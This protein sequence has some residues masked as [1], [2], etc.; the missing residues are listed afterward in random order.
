MFILLGTKEHFLHILSFYPKYL[1]CVFCEMFN[2]SLKHFQKN[3]QGVKER[4]TWGS[5]LILKQICIAAMDWIV[6]TLNSQLIVLGSRAFGR[7][8]WVFDGGPSWWDYPL[9]LFLSYSPSSSF[10]SPTTIE[11]TARRK[12]P[13]SSQEYLHLNSIVCHFDVS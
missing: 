3:E 10:P 6:S 9:S 7:L 13:D 4:M 2:S 8:T 11:N 5:V 1:L 12:G